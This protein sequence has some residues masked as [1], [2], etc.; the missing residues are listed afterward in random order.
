MKK[1]LLI[2][3]AFI[4][5]VIQTSVASSVKILDVAPNLIFIFAIVYGLDSTTFSAGVV[6]C[7]CGILTDCADCTFIGHSALVLMY[8]SFLSSLIS[9]KFYYDNKLVGILIVFA[10]SI[11]YEFIRFF[12]ASIMTA[13]AGTAYMLFRYILPEAVYNSVLSVPLMW[14][15]KWLKNEYIRG[16]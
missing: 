11:A 12:I 15:I 4:L 2:L 13:D 6:G 8:V 3:T 16:I 7:L 10:S 5:A 14:W 9:K 1:I